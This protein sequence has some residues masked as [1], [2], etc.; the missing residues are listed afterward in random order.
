MP[1]TFSNREI[2]DIHFVYG[3]VNGNSRA[4]VREYR[5]RYPERRHP[6]RNVFVKVHRQLIE[7]GLGNLHV[8]RNNANRNQQQR[9]ISRRILNEFDRDPTMSSRI[10]SRILRTSKSN[11]LRTLRRDHRRPF[12]LQPV[13]GLHPGDEERRMNFC[14]WVLHSVQQNRDF[15]NRIL[16]TDESCFTRRGIVNFH[17]QHVWAHENP[18]AIRP[19]NFQVEFSVNVWIGIYNNNLFGPYFLPRRLNAEN[20][21][22]FLEMEHHNMWDQIP[23]IL[24]QNAWFQLDGCPAHFGR[25]VRN[26]LDNNF[27]ERWIGRGGPVP[28]PPRSPD[29]TVLDFFVWGFLKEKVYATPVNTQ[30]ELINRIRNACN[31]IIPHLANLNR[32]IVRRCELCIEKNGS[33][34]EQFL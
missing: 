10:A 8:D 17:N 28:W 29:L 32:S 12:H 20:F 14:R 7:N 21:L 16:W 30:D 19:R 18:H 22:Q 34:F 33:H 5:R 13:Q 26:W 23:I 25:I 15:L 3:F 11:I 6:S 24:R 27:P 9:R 2:A 1:F 4:A 31:E